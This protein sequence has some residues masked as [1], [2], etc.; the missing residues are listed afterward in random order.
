MII[1]D[2]YINEDKKKFDFSLIVIF[3]NEFLKEDIKAIFYFC[4]NDDGMLNIKRIFFSG[5]DSVIDVWNSLNEKNREQVMGDLSVGLDVYF[6]NRAF[7][8]HSIEDKVLII[9]NGE[10]YFDFLDTGK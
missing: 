8:W 9:E 1:K 7:F 6:N 3:T 10:Y 4:L 2:I 5:E